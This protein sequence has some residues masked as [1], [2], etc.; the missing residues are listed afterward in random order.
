MET[1]SARPG[2]TS[3]GN[4]SVTGLSVTGSTEDRLNL[5]S[6]AKDQTPQAA[7]S[8]EQDVA[9]Q[10]TPAIWTVWKAQNSLWY[11]GLHNLHSEIGEA[12]ETQQSAE[13]VIKRCIRR[14]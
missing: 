12:E 14:R 3:L 1:D 8:L 10:P 9:R 4:C 6:Q 7:S 5:V 11:P 13:R 2:L